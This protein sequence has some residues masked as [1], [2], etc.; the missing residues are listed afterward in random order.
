MGMASLK[1]RRDVL[2]CLGKSTSLG[3]EVDGI[4]PP[5]S[6]IIHEGKLS[7][8]AFYE[9]CWWLLAEKE[10][11]GPVLA[12]LLPHLLVGCTLDSLLLWDKTFFLLYELSGPSLGTKDA[13]PALQYPLQSVQASRKTNS[14]QKPASTHAAHS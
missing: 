6:P 11:T 7:S 4:T 10:L 1:I 13:S 9:R 2:G 12:F 14:D 3:I 5:C 8:N